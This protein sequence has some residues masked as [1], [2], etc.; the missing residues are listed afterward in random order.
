MVTIIITIIASFAALISLILSFVF[1][2]KRDERALKCWWL[3]WITL[4]IALGSLLV[5]SRPRYPKEELKQFKE[6]KKNEHHSYF[7]YINSHCS[8]C[9]YN[10]GICSETAHS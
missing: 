6:E 7:G 1:Y 10:I 8:A 4:F 9:Q 5:E 2:E 3:F